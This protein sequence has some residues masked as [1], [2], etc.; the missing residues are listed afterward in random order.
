VRK[1]EI[2]V[3]FTKGWLDFSKHAAMS[4][5]YKR[6]VKSEKGKIVLTSILL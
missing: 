3:D 4:R 5:K 6:G 2:G 1:G